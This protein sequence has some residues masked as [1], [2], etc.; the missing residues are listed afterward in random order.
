MGD[1]NSRF[2]GNDGV[3]ELLIGIKTE[4]VSVEFETFYFQNMSPPSRTTG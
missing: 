1:Y 4:A 3:L 2:N